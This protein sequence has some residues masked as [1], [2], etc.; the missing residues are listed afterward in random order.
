MS[1]Y[2]RTIK[3]PVSIKENKTANYLNHGVISSVKIAC[4]NQFGDRNNE[5]RTWKG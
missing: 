2:I 4:G 1:P 5:E 3:P